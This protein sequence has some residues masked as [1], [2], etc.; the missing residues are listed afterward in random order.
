MHLKKC[1]YYV[2][3]SVHVILHMWPA[4]RKGT[5]WDKSSISSNSQ[6]SVKS[7]FLQFLVFSL[8]ENSTSWL[9]F[10]MLRVHICGMQVDVMRHNRMFRYVLIWILMAIFWKRWIGTQVY[11]NYHNSAC[12]H[13]FLLKLSPLYST[14]KG[15]SIHIK[16]SLLVKIP[17]GPFSHSRSHM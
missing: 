14:Q 3:Q 5:I 10:Y 11:K 12:G 17:N 2:I 1:T 8:S 13:Y 9:Y 7:Y 4:M 6:R 15:L 16:S